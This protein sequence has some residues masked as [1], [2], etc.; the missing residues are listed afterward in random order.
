ME[1]DG[2]HIILVTVYNTTCTEAVVKKQT[3]IP[4]FDQL[5]SSDRSRNG[6]RYSA[7]QPPLNT[8]PLV[9]SHGRWFHNLATLSPQPHPNITEARYTTNTHTEPRRGRIAAGRA[10]R[11]SGGEKEHTPSSHPDPRRFPPSRAGKSRRLLI[12]Y[13]QRPIHSPRPPCPCP[14]SN[15]L[16]HP[17]TPTNQRR[18]RVRYFEAGNALTERPARSSAPRAADRTRAGGA[19][20][21]RR[22]LPQRRT[23]GRHGNRRSEKFSQFA[24]PGTGGYSSARAL[25]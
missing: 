23:A 10:L 24:P 21:C 20:P 13:N 5:A 19:K 6:T 4:S 2:I 3:K 22:W 1:Y 18:L 7:L 11:S 12:R 14:L 25:F 17:S 15:H 8:P 9:S 16:S